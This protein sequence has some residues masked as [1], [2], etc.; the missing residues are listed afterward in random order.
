MQTLG[1]DKGYSM[2][3]VSLV[4]WQRDDAFKEK[5]R[6]CQQLPAIKKQRAK[7]VGKN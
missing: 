5:V 6:I 7:Q 2:N 4:Y 3:P 1:G